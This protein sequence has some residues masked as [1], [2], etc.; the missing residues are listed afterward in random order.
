MPD[1]NALLA[2]L[3]AEHEALDALVADLDDEQWDLPTPAEGWSIRDQISHLAFFD[4]QARRSI[5]DPEAFTRDVEEYLTRALTEGEQPTDDVDMGRAMRPA[6]LLAHWRQ[7][8]KALVAAGATQDPK[9]RCPWF[10]PE[11]GIASFLTARLMETWAHGLD[12]ED[13]LGVR[14][15]V[16]DRL[17]HICHIGIGARPFAYASRQMEMPDDP[18]RI[19]VTLPSG[20]LWTWGPE[21]AA[22]RITGTA[23]DLA[24]IVIQ[25]RNPADTNIQV[26]GDA[27]TE[28]IG[29]AQAFA[30][31]PTTNREAGLFDP[32]APSQAHGE[33]VELP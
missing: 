33:N 23:L 7:E 27:A 21:D 22:D 18:I 14:R 24:M 17:A 4:T 29:I 5:E 30:G 12:V 26:T 31:L 2:D 6:D 10:G 3:E 15:E 13:T 16:T 19:E 25:R 32:I 1:L 11:M 20:A 9:R 28:W 8:R